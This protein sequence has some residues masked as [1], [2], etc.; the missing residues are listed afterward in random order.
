MLQ[1]RSLRWLAAYFLAVL[2]KHTATLS[3]ACAALDEVIGLLHASNAA[4]A[5]CSSFLHVLP[6]TSTKTVPITKS[7]STV[8]S[9]VITITVTGGHVG[10]TVT[11]TATADTTTVVSTMYLRLPS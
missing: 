4:S 8:L 5:F 10:G 3:P 1:Q 2:P 9:D 11:V 6:V 7:T